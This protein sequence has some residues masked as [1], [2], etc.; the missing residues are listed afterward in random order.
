MSVFGR[1]SSVVGP[2]YISSIHQKLTNITCIYYKSCSGD[3]KRKTQERAEFVKCLKLVIISIKE[4]NFYHWSNCKER[5][6]FLKS[7]NSIPQYEKWVFK[8]QETNWICYKQNS[9]PVPN[10]N[11]API[12]Q[13]MFDQG[14]I[15]TSNARAMY[16]KAETIKINWFMR[17]S[18]AIFSAA[19]VHY[20][21]QNNIRTNKAGQ[22]FFNRRF[23]K[24][25]SLYL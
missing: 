25:I 2:F 23:N 7:V 19:L 10:P 12:D 11:N 5:A 21:N 1:R 6:A 13:Y 24:Q 8:I 15:T 18:I 22:V 17:N 14:R 4:D 16:Y 3:N 20:L 9:R